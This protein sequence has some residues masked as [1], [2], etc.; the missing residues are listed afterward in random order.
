MIVRNGWDFTKKDRKGPAGVSI[1]LTR[2][3]SVSAKVGVGFRKIGG[4]QEDGTD[5]AMLHMYLSM[6]CGLNK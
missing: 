2:L 6:Y 4:S 1:V 3:T 5:D